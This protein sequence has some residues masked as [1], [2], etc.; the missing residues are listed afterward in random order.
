MKLLFENWR[1]YTL[2]T[3]EQLI[4]EGRI[5]DTKTKYPE[6]GKKREE[7]DGESLLDVLIAGDPSGNQKYL[8][9]AAS[10][11]QKSMETAEQQYK[12][13]WGKL[14]P[15]GDPD[16]V[17]SP[18]GVANNIAGLLSQYHDLMPFI[19]D[20]DAPFKDFNK[21]PDTP[22]LNAIV[23]T[24]GDKKEAQAREKEDKKRYSKQAKEESEVVLD[25]PYH[26][27]IRPLTAH[28][29]CYFGRGTKWCIS[30][31]RASNYFDQY[32]SEGKSFYFLL[33]KNK[34]VGDAYKKMAM[35]FERDGNFD[36]VYDSEDDSL[37][38]E[39][40]VGALAE[41]MVGSETWN[42]IVS[43]EEDEPYKES[44]I[45][46]GLKSFVD[47]GFMEDLDLKDIIN[48][49]REGS[50]EDYQSELIE[51]ASV[52]TLNNPGGIPDEAYEEKLAEYDFQHIDVTLHFPY[53]TGAE[54][55]YWEAGL[56][57]DVEGIFS[58]FT[59][60][61]SATQPEGHP[62]YEQYRLVGD[63]SDLS[64]ETRNAVDTALNAINIYPEDIEQN[65]WGNPAEFTIRIAGTS[66]DLDQFENWL[67]D[68][69]FDDASVSD[70]FTEELME[71]L[72]EE[73]VIEDI[74]KAAAEKEEERKQ[75]RDYEY[76]PDPAEKEKQ[77][78][79]PLQENRIRIKITKKR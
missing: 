63:I 39:Q 59:A 48:T 61:A 36:E 54:Y 44:I 37:T 3:E 23:K 17:Y 49:F 9:H 55:V 35:V 64:D 76:W 57:I 34:D 18:W 53:D 31:T 38:H 46:D 30:A 60:A 77:I 28:A 33:A 16:D 62:R 25:T 32:T 42:E 67:D 22:A 15:E 78:E 72:E 20:E 69:K 50:L 26:M 19:R 45:R 47:L 5:D 40:F 13:F 75:T 65:D 43:F 41:T 66:G 58:D 52:D 1:K 68:M 56:Y 2:L 73:G 74:E 8:M 7:L 14:W 70:S 11:L 10:L 12:P 27:V 21:V 29:S 51:A 71:A 4:I 79:L 24:A 6:I